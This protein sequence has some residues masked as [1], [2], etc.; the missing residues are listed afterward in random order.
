MAQ[1]QSPNSAPTTLEGT[2]PHQHEQV[3]D[4]MLQKFS[5]KGGLYHQQPGI[6]YSGELRKWVVTSPDLI[7]QAMH[8][9]A[10]S[11]PDYDLS[12]VISRA[13]ADLHCLNELKNYF[14]LAKEGEPHMALRERFA[15]HVSSRTRP[16]LDIF[17]AKFDEHLGKLAALPD[18]EAFCLYLELLRP[19]VRKAVLSLADLDTDLEFDVESLPQLFDSYLSVSRR[20]KIND[21]VRDILS[22]LPDGMSPDERYF[23]VAVVALASNT[24]L[25]TLAL[26]AVDRLRSE[27][28]IS[29]KDIAWGSDITITGLP[30]IEKHALKDTLLGGQTIRKGERVRLFIEAGGVSADG[31]PGYS[32]LFFAVGPHKC[33]G[34][35]FG[36]QIW[37]RFAA[38][39]RRLDRK[40]RL[41]EV[42]DR[43]CDYVFNFP[44]RIQVEFHV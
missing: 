24:I 40:L 25:S 43:E 10:L 6:R 16:A 23:R 1:D 12:E 3:S 28:G 30:L 41:I 29:L 20:R 19:S 33:V 26:N 39:V 13:N 36:R 35:S 22:A 5:G 32:E 17:T 15:R 4:F 44:E 11:V 7:R 42:R 2:C 9:E 21:L 18:G 14:P 34:M 31:K 37:S 8:D 38:S 27:P